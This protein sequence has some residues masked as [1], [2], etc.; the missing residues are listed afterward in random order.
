MSGCTKEAKEICA[1]R[2]D[3]GRCRKLDVYI[4]EQRDQLQ[5]KR[6]THGSEL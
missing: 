2:D 4:D 6:C 5:G 1:F 3:H